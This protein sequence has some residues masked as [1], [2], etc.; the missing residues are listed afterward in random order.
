MAN[1][2]EPA[3]ALADAS[4][5]ALFDP[6]A[7]PVSTAR[8]R[9]E[10]AKR[11]GTLGRVLEN[12]GWLLAGKGFSAILG[13]A[14]TAILARSLG[15]QD[16]G[17]FVLV[18]G[19]AA[20]VSSFV[21]FQTWQAMVRF[22]MDHVRETISPGLSRLTAFC[23][24]LDL[25]GAIVGCILAGV[26]VL[27]LGPSFE[28]SPG[29]Q[30]EVLLFCCVMLL[31]IRSAASGLLRVHDQFALG[32]AADSVQA[33]M[34]MVGAVVV[35]LVEPT[36]RHFLLAWA[37]AEVTM[38]LVY[39]ILA[40]RTEGWDLRSVSWR[41]VRSVPGEH[42]GLWQ[43]VAITNAG[44]TLRSISRQLP[45]LLVGLVVG[46]AAAGAYRL[47]HQLGQAL[48]RIGDLLSRAIFAELARL[49]SGGGGDKLNTLFRSS[50]RLA[51]GGAVVI[52]AVLLLIG[53][54]LLRLVAPAFV[55]AYPLLLILG[56]AAA[57]EMVGVSFE[58]ALMATGRAGT[59]FRLRVMVTLFLLVMM[60]ILLPALG[61][62][63]AAFANLSSACFAVL[64]FG[65]FTRR[66]MLQKDGVP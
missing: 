32:A 59:A 46:T 12:A 54:P 4:H 38:A 34:R 6:S 15:R 41:D 29:F 21:A 20:L 58:P 48:A 33:A 64:L 50:T 7:G 62:R 56:I 16:F 5:C 25:G 47:A 19:T 53:E 35:L 52:V 2:S 1:L 63:G 43:F 57:V 37:V 61:A 31:S 14:Y 27:L 36:V 49:H 22:G 17:E 39:W 44:V 26:A 8:K 3:R 40:A 13:V 55:G 60:A 9:S 65:W 42:P 51:L 28:W 23:I 11:S 66:A 45:V 18:V 30:L 24:A 10:R